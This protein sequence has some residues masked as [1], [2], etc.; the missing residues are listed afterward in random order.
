MR[1]NKLRIW[2]AAFLASAV[3]VTSAPVM[4]YQSLPSDGPE[5]RVGDTN[6]SANN[7]N[8]MKLWYQTPGSNWLYDGLPIGNGNLGAMILGRTETEKVQLNEITLWTGGPNTPGYTG[9]IVKD[10]YK[11]LPEVRESLFAGKLDEAYERSK[12]L[13]GTGRGLEAYQNL[14]DFTLDFTGNARTPNP[15]NYRRELDLN[16]GIARVA[17]ENNGIKFTR[18]YLASNPGNVMAVHLTSDKDNAIGFKLKLTP[19]ASANPYSQVG[20]TYTTT[21]RNGVISC[22]GTVA[23]SQMKFAVQM[24]VVAPNAD[25]T[26]NSD[27]TV[28]VA[29]GEDVTLYMTAGTNYDQTESKLIQSIDSFK[30]V[31]YLDDHDPN[32]DVA[33]SKAAARIDT[34]SQMS[35]SDFKAIHMQDYQHLFNTVS[36]NLGGI[37]DANRPTNELMRDYQTGKKESRYI[38]TLLF[39]FGRYLLISSS[40]NSLPANLQGIWNNSNKPMWASDYH[41]NV[42]MQMIYWPAFVTNIDETA[43]PVIPFLRSLM[44]PGKVAA[45]EHFGVDN[46]SWVVNHTTNIFGM[47]APG[48]SID[49]GLAP[50]SAAWVSMILWDYYQYTQDGEILK[51]IYPILRDQAKFWKGFL[52]LDP[53]TGEY[54]TAPSTSPEHGPV[55]VGTTYDMSLAYMLLEDVVEAS[56]VMGQDDDLRAELE[57]I[58]AKMDP[59][60]I[61]KSGQ[62]KE[63]REED[64]YNKRTDGTSIGDPTHRHL[65]QLMGLYNGDMITKEDKE[66]MDAAIKSLELRGD[67]GWDA[68][69]WSMALRMLLWSRIGDGDRALTLYQDA[70]KYAMLQNLMSSALGFVY[71]M[72]ANGGVTAGVAEML[73]Q[74]YA[75]YIKPLPALPQDWAAGSYTGLKAIGNFECD[76]VWSDNNLNQFTVRS[77]SG[78]PLKVRYPGIGHASVKSNGANVDFTVIDANTIELN[79]IKDAEYVIN[80]IPMRLTAPTNLEAYRLDDHKVD[81]TWN[82][83]ADSGVTYNLY[84]MVEG[85]VYELYASNLTAAKYQ[86]I[87]ADASLGNIY[88][89]V[90]AVKDHKE[91]MQSKPIK[92]IKRNIALKKP[93]TTNSEQGNNLAVYGNDGSEQ[94]RWCGNT[95]SQV[96]WW[97]VDLQDT[98]NIAGSKLIWES[99]NQEMYYKMEVSD[100]G[101]TWETVVNRYDS[102]SVTEKAT[103]D[104]WSAQH[105]R[106]IKITFPGSPKVPGNP[107]VWSGF[108]EFEVYADS[109]PVVS[110]N[111][112]AAASSEQAGHEA[113]KANDGDLATVWKAADHDP[114]K[115]WT[116]D[117]EE[118][119]DVTEIELEWA[120]ENASKYKVEISSD[121]KVW[122]QAVDRTKDAESSKVK[123]DRVSNQEVRYV[124]VTFTEGIASMNEI[125]VRGT[126]SVILPESSNVVLNKPAT[127]D[128]Q[129]GN[130]PASAGNDGNESTRWCVAD[131]KNP[132]YWLVNLGGKYDVTGSKVIFENGG[133]AMLYKIEVSSDAATWTTVI[134]HM[135]NTTN[136]E[137]VRKDNWTAKGAQYIKVTVMGYPELWAGFRE[138]EAYGAKSTVVDTTALK[139]AIA[140]AQVKV[141]HAVVGNQPGQYPQAAVDALKTAIAVAERVVDTAATQ[142]DVTAGIAA[143]QS[144]VK[145]FDDAAATAAPSSSITAPATVTAGKTFNVQVGLSGVTQGVYAQ[146]LSVEF[147]PAKLEFL[148]AK[149]LILGVSIIDKKTTPDGKLRF[150]VAS[151]GPSNA[152]TGTKNVLELTFKAK[153][154]AEASVNSVISMTKVMISDAE[155]AEMTIGNASST[156]QVVKE[157]Q[158]VANGDLNGDGK[159][160]I[161]DLAIAAANYGATKDSPNWNK[162]RMADFDNNGVIDISDLAAI[163]QK[164]IQ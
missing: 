99:D 72:D 11:A 126:K 103:E 62:I 123:T 82:A 141:D 138:F 48:E 122:T 22:Q 19:D 142:A 154:V 117:L 107:A 15:T 8:A 71:Q 29:N 131:D 18:E 10:A 88:Y 132:H 76:A 159:V 1:T 133:K 121:N 40:R 85:G 93:V 96:Q 90:A 33:M 109:T 120:A 69:G 152:V 104:K 26:T 66:Q 12:K 146:D 137:K 164:I 16:E 125:R 80:N 102:H 51:Q 81:V 91:G 17:Y 134:D 61:G 75:G 118:K 87:G 57:A 36:L 84:H 28:T 112:P 31:D 56:K 46:G 3:M 5:T 60:K 4:A 47:T 41:L 64:E 108:R 52:V 55:G 106:F 98:Y 128:S 162:L 6:S 101:N 27:G 158:P 37:E 163:A 79:T 23:G 156:V 94:S 130:N 78:K 25:I 83:V 73:I 136:I 95:P 160:T 7:S 59:I 143:L 50:G 65:S 116:V 149:S 89:K 70:I 100:D 151:E 44:A 35:Y 13:L 32:G 115:T 49:W 20:K 148:S 24:K 42:N 45:K 150:I 124:K 21:A 77:R 157:Q 119:Y 30:K 110:D 34:V 53:N 111:K 129:Q 67:M 135:N 145:A 97:K 155:G 14:G 153:E 68:N 92:A 140:A 9:G 63:W 38:E 2:F 58:L 161:G 127:S 113:S 86:D 54:V 114:M 74:S 139:A 39:Q 147:D 43:N 105:V 144:A